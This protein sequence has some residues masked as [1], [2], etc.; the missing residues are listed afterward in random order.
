VIVALNLAPVA[1]G[2]DEVA[3]SN[4]FESDSSDLK[5]R[6]FAVVGWLNGQ[7]LVPSPFRSG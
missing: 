1:A 2:H 7:A 3:H 6:N 4:M 5:A